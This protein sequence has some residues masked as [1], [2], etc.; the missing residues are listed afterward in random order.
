MKFIWNEAKQLK[1]RIKHGF[2]F[3]DAVC[4]FMGATATFEDNSI[5]YNEQRFIT[6]GF[7]D[8]QAVAIVHTETINEIR[9]ISMRKATRHEEKRLLSYIS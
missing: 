8:G 1:N 3:A 5:R 2:D 9:I 4:V 6:F 7:L